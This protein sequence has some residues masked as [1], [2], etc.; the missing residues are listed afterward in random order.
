MILGESSVGC[1]T[2]TSLSPVL[3]QNLWILSSFPHFVGICRDTYGFALG[4]LRFL[5]SCFRLSSNLGLYLTNCLFRGTRSLEFWTQT[6]ARHV[7][8]RKCVLSCL[9]IEAINELVC[10][11]AHIGSLISQ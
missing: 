5:P 3:V 9:N 2:S 7:S 11:H 1:S 8:S 6:G 4:L 10:I